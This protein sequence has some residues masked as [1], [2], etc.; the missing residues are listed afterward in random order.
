V[1]GWDAKKVALNQEK[2]GVSFQD[3][4]TAFADVKGLDGEDIEHSARELR[5]LRLAK[6]ASGKILVIAYTVRR[7]GHEEI[8]RII[9]ARPASRKERKRYQTED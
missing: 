2:H 6:A 1:F 9:S 4:S 7:H 5:R 8:R 3:A